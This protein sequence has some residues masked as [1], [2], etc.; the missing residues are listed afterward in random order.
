[1]MI[2]EFLTFLLLGLVLAL[3]YG[4]V[5]QIMRLRQRLRDAES[6]CLKQRDL[7]RQCQN[8]RLV[9]EREEAGLGRQ[10]MK[11]EDE[12]RL[13]LGEVED[14]K[15]DNADI[16]ESLLRKRTPIAPELRD[17]PSDHEAGMAGDLGMAE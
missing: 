11:L 17:S 5:M 1:M 2:L 8:E 15:R 14:L 9:L 4:S 16:V 12:L 13:L 10:R 3:K 7:L 6:R